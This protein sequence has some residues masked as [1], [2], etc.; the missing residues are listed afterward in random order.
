MTKKA[1]DPVV[2]DEICPVCKSSRYLNPKMVLLVSPCYHKMCETCVN[3]LFLHGSAPCPIC[4]TALRKGNF[5]LPVFEDLLVEKECRIRKIVGKTFYKRAEDFEN[6]GAYNDYLEEVEEI[7]LN[8]VHDVDVQATFAKL[9]SF[10]AEHRDLIERNLARQAHELRQEQAGEEAELRRREVERKRLM[11][12][13]E[14]KQLAPLK[15]QQQIIEQLATS[16]TPAAVI[17]ASV[18]G[19]EQGSAS[20][21]KRLRSSAT[22]STAQ[23]SSAAA[24]LSSYRGLKSKGID[25]ASTTSIVHFDPFLYSREHRVN[26]T[27]L[28]LTALDALPD[29]LVLQLTEELLPPA[30]RHLARTISWDIGTQMK[31]AGYSLDTIKRHCLRAAL[32]WGL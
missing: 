4:S 16:D 30:P 19:P 23:A 2:E 20:A 26:Q 9:D 10:K 3:R 13:L 24:T 5:V 22:R 28:P 1:A 14:E 11:E 7:V 31:A 8:L 15:A 6:D 27:V 18:Q 12:E 17:M 25:P 32:S 29:G 21:P